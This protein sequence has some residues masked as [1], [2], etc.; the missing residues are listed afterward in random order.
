[1]VQAAAQTGQQT[2]VAGG[3]SMVDIRFR[4]PA[5]KQ[6]EHR[7]QH[8][9]HGMERIRIGHI[10]ILP[11]ADIGEQFHKIPAL[12]KRERVDAFFLKQT[13]Q[14]IPIRAVQPYQ[15]PQGSLLVCGKQDRL[16]LPVEAEGIIQ[17]NFLHLFHVG[18]QLIHK[19]SPV[20]C[21]GTDDPEGEFLPGHG[22]N[23]S[24]HPCGYAAVNIGIRPL[25]HQTDTHGHAPFFSMQ[26]VSALALSR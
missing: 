4:N 12:Q 15:F 8:R 16:P 17:K 21:F 2:A 5:R 25:Q 1:M 13:V 11:Q 19:L 14:H 22:L 6:V 18:R 20:L 3:D 10:R 24:V 23:K 7:Q 26:T 9:T